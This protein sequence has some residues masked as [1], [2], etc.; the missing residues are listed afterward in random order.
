MLSELWKC[1][2]NYWT[3]NRLKKLLKQKV[4]VPSPT[5]Q[6]PEPVA[7]ELQNLTVLKAPPSP[8]PPTH[9]TTLFG[10]VTSTM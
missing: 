1:S 7:S 3:S 5:F 2:R 6:L 4:Q 9:F 8:P 10:E